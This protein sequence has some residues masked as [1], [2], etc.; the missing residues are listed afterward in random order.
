MPIKLKY[1]FYAE[2]VVNIFV[3][4]VAFFFPTVLFDILFGGIVGFNHFSVDLSYWYA[5][6]LIVISYIMLKSLRKE[7]ETAMLYVLEGYLLGDVLQL[8]VVFVRVPFGL[9]LN[10]GIL[11]TVGF[12]LLLMVSRILVITK[13]SFLGFSEQT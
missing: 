1:V 8:S 10:L 9:P 13:P 2:V 12:S 4:F 11:F 6:L 5:V 7:N 3:V